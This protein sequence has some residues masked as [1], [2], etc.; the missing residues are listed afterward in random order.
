[1]KGR[2]GQRAYTDRIPGELAGAMAEWTA[3]TGRTIGADRRLPLRGRGGDPRRDGHDRRH[4]DR[5]RR[6]P[7]RARVGRS[8][9]SPSPASG[10]SRPPSSRAALRRARA[11]GVVERTDEPLA[12][13]QPADPRDPVVA[14]RRRGRRRDGPARPVVL[15]RAR[16]ARRRRGRPRRG[17]RSPRQPRRAVR[18]MHAVLGH[19]SPAR[20]RARADRPP[21]GRRLVAARPFDRRVRLGHDEQARGDARRRAVR[22]AR[23]G[24]SALRLREE[25]PADDVLP[26]DR[27]RADPPPR[28]AGSGRVRA[29]PR[30]R[31]RS[32]SAIRSPG[33]SMAATSSSSRRSPTR[34]RSG[35][36]SRPR[37]GPSSSPAGSG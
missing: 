19:P 16:L 33:S 2:I 35:P 24:L 18:A 34:R 12:A 1:M 5:R 36:R 7:P 28:R 3:L 9:A 6:P 27:R 14:L 30:R 11:V 29:A 31:R 17:L 32:G 26:D 21:A 10:R 8:A 23:P 13:A 15:G 37:C 20:A 4:R 22:Q 25:G